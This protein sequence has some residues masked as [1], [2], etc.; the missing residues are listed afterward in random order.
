MN[1]NLKLKADNLFQVMLVI[2][3]LLTTNSRFL[4]KTEI[5]TFPLGSVPGITLVLG[6]IAGVTN[7]T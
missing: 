6:G 2:P 3:L 4:P 7:P 1:L 5:I